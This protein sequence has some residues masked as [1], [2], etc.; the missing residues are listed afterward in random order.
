MR[1][2]SAMNNG[3]KGKEHPYGRSDSMEILMGAGTAHRNNMR[4]SKDN[5]EMER[6]TKRILDDKL[7]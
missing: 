1:T 5:M 3:P 6:I 2:Q 4:G 7:S